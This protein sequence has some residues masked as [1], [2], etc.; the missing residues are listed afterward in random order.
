VRTICT[1]FFDKQRR[2]LFQIIALTILNKQRFR[3]GWY[4]TKPKTCRITDP[5]ISSQAMCNTIA[6][7]LNTSYKEDITAGDSLFDVVDK[8]AT[9]REVLPWLVD[10]LHSYNTVSLTNYRFLNTNRR[11]S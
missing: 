6:L 4:S 5:S 2:A 7:S 8:R 3:E 11:K 9:G 1:L 10:G